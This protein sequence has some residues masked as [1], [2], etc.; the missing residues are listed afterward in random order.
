MRKRRDSLVFLSPVPWE[1][2]H[3]GRCLSR[4][5]AGTPRE[6]YASIAVQVLACTQYLVDSNVKEW[7]TW[8][9]P[10]AQR[11]QRLR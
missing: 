5:D 11:S 8:Q 4:R 10:K 2:G 6:N 9:I 7:R 1:R 3:P